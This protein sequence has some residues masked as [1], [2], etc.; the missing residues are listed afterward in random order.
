MIIGKNVTVSIVGD[1]VTLTFDASKTFG[2]SASGKTT[3]VATTSGN[4]VLDNG[5]TVGLNVYTK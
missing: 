5:V 4:K 3:I 1:I 2:R